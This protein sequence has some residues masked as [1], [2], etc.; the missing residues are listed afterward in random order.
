MNRH[1]L[2]ILIV[3]SF[4]TAG[5][6]QDLTL[7]I[8]WTHQFQF[9]GYYAAKELGFYEDVGLDVTIVEAEDQT[10]VI[11][12]I[13]SGRASFAIGMPDALASHAEGKKVAIVAPIFPHSPFVLLARKSVAGDNLQ[14]LKSKRIVIGESGSRELLAMLNSA[15]IEQ[16]NTTFIPQS[17]SNDDIINGTID[18]KAFYRVE[19]PRFF[20][21]N[22]VLDYT[23]FEPVNYGV[24]FYGDCIL[25]HSDTLDRNRELVQKFRE[26]SIKGWNYALDN[27]LEVV[28]I[29][30]DKYP[31]GLSKEELLREAA[32]VYNLMLPQYIA[33]GSGSNDRW[34]KI[35]DTYKSLGMISADYTLDTTIIY[36][37]D[38]V[39]TIPLWIYQTI[40]FLFILLVISLLFTRK[41]KREIRKKVTELRHNELRFHTIF[42]DSTQ[43]SGIIDTDGKLILANQNALEMA[44]VT[45]EQVKGQDF[46]RAPWW[47]HSTKIQD[48]LKAVLEEAKGGEQASFEASHVDVNGKIHIID[49]SLKPVINEEG[50]VDFLIATG[51]DLTHL[52]EI[53]DRDRHLQKMEAIGTLAGGIAHDFNNILSAIF[54]YLDVASLEEH[55]N[56][57]LHEAHSEIRTAAKRAKD[58]VGQILTFSRKSSVKMEPIQ[59]AQVVKE[60]LKLIRSSIPATISIKHRINDD[61][62]ILA[63]STQIHQVLMNICTNGYHAMKEQSSGL[64]SVSLTLVEVS[65]EMKEQHPELNN[66]EYLELHISDTGSGMDNATL[67]QVF[68]PY[69]T[70][71]DQENKGTGLGLSTVHTIITSHDGTIDVISKSGV[72]TTFIMLFPKIDH[73]PIEVPQEK[74]APQKVKSSSED[75]PHILFVDDEVMIVKSFG[76]FL[77]HAGFEVTTFTDSIEAL[78]EFEASPDKYSIV[79]SDMSMPM[80]NGV[81]MLMQ[82]KAIRDDIPVILCSGYNQVED[83]LRESVPEI[84][85]YLQKPIG[86]DEIISEVQ[87]LLR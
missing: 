44:G 28:S 62:Y 5:E 74:D 19:L 70:T 15:G 36:Q 32:E 27:Q 4:V 7:Q 16:T 65:D 31:T 2:F 49:F 41:L 76:K 85:Q 82:M 59:L 52:R 21:E 30:I 14:N 86:M 72:G 8:K 3:V 1:I 57:H 40:T 48:K 13:T 78:D 71:K 68:N 81:D 69:F 9:A 34:R 53:E 77:R 38:Q 17:F 67:E 80:M 37:S 29:I 42:D 12:E 46:W 35:V 73:T 10:N 33:I 84:N 6:L 47:R 56:E 43:L 83:E 22:D 55:N 64:L 51:Y 26:A 45:Q 61:S 79:I 39:V 24:D 63:N 23:I 75:I 11:D 66:G 60:T 87:S 50:D 18:A 20:S 58:L 25:T 54:G